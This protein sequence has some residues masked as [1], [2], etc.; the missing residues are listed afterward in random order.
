MKNNDFL[1]ILESFPGKEEL[2]ERIPNRL[3]FPDMDFLAIAKQIREEKPQ[4]FLGKNEDMWVQYIVLE[5]FAMENLARKNLE[6]EIWNT[7][8]ILSPKSIRSSRKICEKFNQFL[9]DGSQVLT[10]AAIGLD[11]LHKFLQENDLF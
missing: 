10:V 11:E 4:L 7:A 5:N 3:E 6:E 2:K 9:E 8:D 1:K